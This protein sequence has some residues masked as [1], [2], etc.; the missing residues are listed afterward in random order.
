M[1]PK[2]GYVSLQPVSFMLYETIRQLLDDDALLGSLSD[3][4][5]RRRVSLLFLRQKIDEAADTHD[6]SRVVGINSLGKEL[7]LSFPRLFFLYSLL[8]ACDIVLSTA[9]RSC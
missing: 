5:T 9:G 6:F 4:L 8:G 2:S 7:L 1:R 3:H